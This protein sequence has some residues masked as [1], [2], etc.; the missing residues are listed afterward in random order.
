MSTRLRPPP[1][2]SRSRSPRAWRTFSRRSSPPA[3]PGKSRS[4]RSNAR[5]RCLRAA[6]G[7]SPSPSADTAFDRN[8]DQLLRLD[9]ELHR[10]LLDHILDEAVDDQRDRLLFVDAALHD[11]ELLVLGD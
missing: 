10:Q 11:V 8:A 7:P 4:R 9:G 5:T 6:P 2:R 3:L 1:A